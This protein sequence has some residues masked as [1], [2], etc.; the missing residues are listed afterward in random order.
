L[1]RFYKKSLIE[2]LIEA[3]GIANTGWLVL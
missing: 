3:D 2:E 1:N